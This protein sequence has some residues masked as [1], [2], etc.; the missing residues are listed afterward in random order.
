MRWRAD[1]IGNR[2]PWS[3]FASV[4]FSFLSRREWSSL[5]PLFINLP[6]SFPPPSIYRLP[7]NAEGWVS[8]TRL[9]RRFGLDRP[10]VPPDCDPFPSKIPHS[11]ARALG[12]SRVYMDSKITFA[13][14]K[15]EEKNQFFSTFVSSD[16]D[17]C[18]YFPRRLAVH[19]NSRP[20]A[21]KLDV[22]YRD[23]ALPAG[24]FCG[25]FP[26]RNYFFICGHRNLLEYYPKNKAKGV[27]CGEERK[28]RRM[29]GGPV[30][31]VII[32]LNGY[33]L[34]SLYFIRL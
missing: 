9:L 18:R 27:G 6:L 26:F 29:E 17:P 34:D 2:W 30:R 23:R 10:F 19:F 21:H 12:V 7:R 8:A 33:M 1:S 5:I 14:N 15:E 11:H 32:H 28:N 4:F 13:Q 22:I 20:V 3:F 31:P 25:Q 24:P 16:D